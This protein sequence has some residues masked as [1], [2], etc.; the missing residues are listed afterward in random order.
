MAVPALP[1]ADKYNKDCPPLILNLVEYSSKNFETYTDELALLGRNGFY[2]SVF[3]RDFKFLEPVV[4]RTADG[5]MHTAEL[6]WMNRFIESDLGDCSTID[7]CAADATAPFVSDTYT[8]TPF[9][10]VVKET[11]TLNEFRKTCDDPESHKMNNI[12]S[13]LA[14]GARSH[15]KKIMTQLIAGKGG[16]ATGSEDVDT[17]GVNIAVSAAGG[18]DAYTLTNALIKADGTIDLR[19]LHELKE[20][21]LVNDATSGATPILIHDFIHPFSTKV[22]TLGQVGCCSDIG[23]DQRAAASAFGGIGRFKSRYVGDA[24]ATAGLDRRKAFFML[25]PGAS[26]YIE[27][28]DFDPRENWYNHGESFGRLFVNPMDG[29][30]WD[31]RVHFIECPAGGGMPQY[32]TTFVKQGMVFNMPET[33]YKVGDFLEGVNGVWELALA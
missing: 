16:W 18:G 25:H 6:T 23:V 29:E 4:N 2:R 3:N 15:E 13:K 14:A 32:V 9:C 17:T 33:L 22:E 20:L 31:M 19:V 21:M 11:M 26:Q 1:V 12:F 30:T 10:T 5:K 7:L 8:F 27:Y 24:I 28:F